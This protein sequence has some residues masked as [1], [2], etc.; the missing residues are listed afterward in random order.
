MLDMSQIETIRHLREQGDAIEEISVKTGVSKPTVIKYLKKDDFSP[1]PPIRQERPSKLDPFKPIVD[2]ILE[3]DR[4]VWRKQRHTAKR[5]YERL[6]DEHG[7]DGSYNTVQRYVKSSRGHEVRAQYLDLVWDPGT[8][9]V[10]FGEADVLE[11]G[12]KVRR[13]FLAVSFPHS[14]MGF[15]QLFSGETAECVCQGLKDIFEHIGGI[16]TLAVFDNAT[17]GRQEGLRS[18]PR[19]EALPCLPAPPRFRG[20]VLQPRLRT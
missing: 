7:Y 10:D 20:E 1:E 2:E 13:Y 11:R 6:R 4:H 19:D 15:S 12:V 9:Q 14:N 16:P 17:G 18:R 3:K 8:V 5:I